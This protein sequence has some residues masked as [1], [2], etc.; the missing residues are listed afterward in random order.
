MGNVMT[1]LLKENYRPITVL[2]AEDEVF[3]QIVAKQL[4][5]MFDHR[6]GL[7]LSACRKTHSCETLIKLIERWSFAT[8]K[9]S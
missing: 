7:V 2:P 8:D 1:P 5:K 9:N 3:E 4:V 6:L